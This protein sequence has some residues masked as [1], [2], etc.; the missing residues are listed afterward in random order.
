MQLGTCGYGKYSGEFEVHISERLLCLHHAR[1]G[2][3]AEVPDGGDSIV[4]G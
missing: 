1:R 3:R 2:S 4:E